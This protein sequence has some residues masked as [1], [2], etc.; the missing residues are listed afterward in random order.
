MILEEID[1]VV[2]LEN[3][4]MKLYCEILIASHRNLKEFSCLND[5][6]SLVPSPKN[7]EEPAS[8]RRLLCLTCETVNLPMAHYAAGPYVSPLVSFFA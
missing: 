4:I 6:L 5:L 1:R 7:A 8:N 3:D 2:E